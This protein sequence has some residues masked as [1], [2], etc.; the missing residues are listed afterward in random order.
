MKYFVLGCSVS[1][2]LCRVRLLSN[3]FIVRCALYV[4]EKPEEV[5][6]EGVKARLKSPP[7]ISM[8]M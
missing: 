6:S 1:H 2:V 5:S 4:V 3:V 8:P 7:T